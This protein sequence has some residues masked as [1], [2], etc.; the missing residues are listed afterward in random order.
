MLLRKL[1]QDE[2]SSISDKYQFNFSDKQS[3]DWWL[4]I[5]IYGESRG[6]VFPPGSFESALNIVDDA[7]E[8]FS[9]LHFSFWDAVNEGISAAIQL[10]ASEISKITKQLNNI[11]E[12]DL[13]QND[14]L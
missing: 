4:K 13:E 8:R 7:K 2:I 6:R 12:E 14:Y 3:L 9:P 11:F 1:H 5:R 10:E